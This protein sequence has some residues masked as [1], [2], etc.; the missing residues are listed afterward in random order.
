VMDIN[1]KGPFYLTVKLLPELRAGATEDDPARVI[2][3]ASIDGLHVNPQEHYPYS[4]SKAGMIHLTRALA[5]RLAPEDITVNAVCPGPFESKMMEYNL[6]KFG[7][8]IR[9]RNPRKRI[10]TP[11]DMAG[12]SIYLAS[13]AAAYVTGAAIPVDGGI[14]AVS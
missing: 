2:N 10:G 5:R 7:D 6:R 4:A 9:A 8:E 14:F 11:E 1:L 3:I 12:V 13:R